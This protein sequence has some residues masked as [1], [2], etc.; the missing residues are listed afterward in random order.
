MRLAALHLCWLS[1]AFST[2]IASLPGT[3][4]LSCWYYILSSGL[5]PDE[6]VLHAL[7]KIHDQTCHADPL[8]VSFLIRQVNCCPI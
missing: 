8:T 7:G 3:S 2:Y 4:F 6:S 1:S 5:S